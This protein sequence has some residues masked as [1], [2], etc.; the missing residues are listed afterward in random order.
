MRMIQQVWADEGRKHLVC[1][2]SYD[3]GILKGRFYHPYGDAETFG[4]LSQFLLKMEEILDQMQMPQSYTSPRK[5]SMLLRDE[6]KAFSAPA[7]RGSRATFELKVIFR[8]HSSWQGVIVWRE[9]KTEH[10]FRSVLELVILMDSA[11]RSLEESRNP[12]N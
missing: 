2:D 8:Q 7:R 10:S 4:S 11:L 3:D 1:V 6:D 5:F 12:R 9:Q